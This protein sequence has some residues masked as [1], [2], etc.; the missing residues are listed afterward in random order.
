MDFWSCIPFIKASS[1]PEDVEVGF[2]NDKE[3]SKTPAVGPS[4]MHDKGQ[5]VA[6]RWQSA[7]A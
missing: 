3:C 4:K 1:K 6:H 2:T 5:A 7:E